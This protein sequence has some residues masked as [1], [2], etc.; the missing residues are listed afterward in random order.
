MSSATL[1]TQKNFERILGGEVE[2][3]HLGRSM[4]GNVVKR[5]VKQNNPQETY[6]LKVQARDKKVYEIGKL[7]LKNILPTTRLRSS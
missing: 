5:I 2:F 7:D 1:E 3:L 6:K 4:R